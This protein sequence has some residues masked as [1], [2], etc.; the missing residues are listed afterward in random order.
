M[1]TITVKDRMGH[2]QTQLA[3]PPFSAEHEAKARKV[4]DLLREHDL[5][6]EREFVTLEIEGETYVVVD[7]GMRMLTPREL[8]TAQGFPT[9]YVIEGV[10]HENGYDWTF[11]AFSKDVQ[12][13][14]VGNS[15]CPQVAKALAEANTQHLIKREAAA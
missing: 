7:V 13:S 14:C 12:I 1:H 3:A 9:D 15:V 8:F 4:A 6:D 2:L 10:W 5:W 11:K